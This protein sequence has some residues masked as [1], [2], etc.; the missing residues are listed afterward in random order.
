MLDGERNEFKGKRVGSDR[1]QD[2]SLYVIGRL[3]VVRENIFNKF[4]KKRKGW[5]MARNVEIGRWG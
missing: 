1:T 4:K 3:H 5:G 2:I